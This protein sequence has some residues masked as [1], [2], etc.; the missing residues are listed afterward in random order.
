MSATNDRLMEK[1]EK[2]EAFGFEEAKQLIGKWVALNWVRVGLMITGTVL[3]GAANI[4]S[5]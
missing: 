4:M 3:G 5:S 2:T 1:A